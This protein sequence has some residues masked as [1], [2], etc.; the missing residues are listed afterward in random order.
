MPL[1]MLRNY[2]SQNCQ[3][4]T[5]QVPGETAVATLPS[6]PNAP[7]VSALVPS[8]PGDPPYVGGRL[9]VSYSMLSWSWGHKWWSV[10]YLNISLC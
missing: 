1:G 6:L 9:R 8:A 4:P 7:C 2:Q 3:S 5:D 10:V